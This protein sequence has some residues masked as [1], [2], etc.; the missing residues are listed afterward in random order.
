MD[1]SLTVLLALLIDALVG[2]PPALYRRL[3]H[4]VVV[5]G[6][7]IG[8]YEPRLNRGPRSL[9]RVNGLLLTVTVVVAAGLVGWLVGLPLGLLPGGGLLEAALA[10]TLLAGRGLHDHVAAVAAGLRRGLAAGRGAVAHIVGRDPAGLDRAGVARAAVESAAENFSD[11]LVAPVLWYLLLGLPGLCAYK[12][13]NTLD[14]M[15]GHRSE[16]YRVFGR[17]AARLDDWANWLPARLSGALLVVAC[18]VTPGADPQRAW[19]VMQRDAGK[20]RSPNAGWPEAAVAGALR[21]ALVGP[22]CYAGQSADD[23]WLGDGTAELDAADIDRVLRLYR[24]AWLVLAAALAALW[25]L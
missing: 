10:S 5:I 9:R 8:R 15:I 13:I 1:H 19:A 16:R 2:D 17:A 21:L 24:R 11:G 23:P 4:P 3:P 12:A 7:W 22:R 18:W 25:L 6:G 20:H 14:S